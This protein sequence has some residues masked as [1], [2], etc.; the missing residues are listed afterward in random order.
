M[1]KLKLVVASS[2]LSVKSRTIAFVP[3]GL[4]FCGPFLFGVKKC[5]NRQ[6]P[7]NPVADN[8]KLCHGLAMKRLC[9]REHFARNRAGVD[10]GLTGRC[11]CSRVVID[12]A[13][14][15]D[16]SAATR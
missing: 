16:F 7:A 15:L 10:N 3:K 2:S 6:T 5:G 11:Y 4:Q 1:A 12:V 8:G 14:L 13:A 9:K